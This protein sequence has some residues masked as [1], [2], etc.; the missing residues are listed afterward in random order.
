VKLA[1]AGGFRPRPKLPRLV[2]EF[3]RSRV[4]QNQPQLFSD[5]VL[6]RKIDTTLKTQK[7]VCLS[8]LTQVSLIGGFLHH[9]KNA[10]NRTPEL[11]V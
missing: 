6:R 5:R 11:L 9:V 1:S 4:T 8:L 10:R 7:R 3:A 2:G